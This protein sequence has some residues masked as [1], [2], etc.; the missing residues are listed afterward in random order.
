MSEYYNPLPKSEVNLELIRGGLRSKL[1]LNFKTIVSF[2]VEHY[3]F[4]F[5]FLMRLFL[6]MCSQNNLVNMVFKLWIFRLHQKLNLWLAIY[7]EIHVKLQ[8]MPDKCRVHGKVQVIQ[9]SLNR[10]FYMASTCLEKVF[11]QTT[12]VAPHMLNQLYSK[13]L[14]HD[15]FFLS[16]CKREK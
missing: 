16:S 13:M 5:F 12:I 6:T 7:G 1:L 9:T 4:F 2:S 3:H 11:S 14:P 8:L 15:I 10:F